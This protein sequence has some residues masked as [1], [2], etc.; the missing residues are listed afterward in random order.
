M[1]SNRVWVFFHLV[2]LDELRGQAE[3]LLDALEADT[4]SCAFEDDSL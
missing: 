3:G 2:V 1:S 4:A